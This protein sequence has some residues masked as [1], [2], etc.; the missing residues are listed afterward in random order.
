MNGGLWERTASFV[1]N[2][3]TALTN[4]GNSIYSEKDRKYVMKY[5][6][7]EQGTTDK[8]VA[9]QN[10]YLANSMVYGNAIQEVSTSGTGD[11]AWGGASSVF[12]AL[13]EPM[14]IRGASLW[15]EDNA[16]LLSF[17]MNVV[18]HHATGFSVVL[19]NE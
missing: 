9:S 8:N 3:N 15:Y 14:S 17:H 16:G 5:I 10:N 18:S 7:N 4:Y 6:S 12:V 19:I 13:R 11:N 1:D 2:G